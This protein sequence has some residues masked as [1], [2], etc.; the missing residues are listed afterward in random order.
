MTNT[1]T[2]TIKNMIDA[3]NN[4]KPPQKP[5]SPTAQS[6]LDTLKNILVS[7]GRL[8]DKFEIKYRKSEEDVAVD[9]KDPMEKIAHALSNAESVLNE[10][11]LVITNALVE[12]EMN[13]DA[14]S[15]AGTQTNVKFGIEPKSS[16]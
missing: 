10:Q 16:H 6:A 9:P 15:G 2:L 3:L 7:D 8:N 1:I 13:I 12:M 14:G 5:L 11:N 4:V